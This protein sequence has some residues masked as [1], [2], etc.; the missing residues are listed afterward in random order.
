MLK[1]ADPVCGMTVDT[2]TTTLT[3]HCPLSNRLT[4]DQLHNIGLQVAWHFP[5]SRT[6]QAKHAHNIA[7]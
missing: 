5:N 1:A 6:V 3:D 7:F 4:P 2:N